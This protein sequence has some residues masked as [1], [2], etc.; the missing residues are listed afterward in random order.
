MVAAAPVLWN[1]LPYKPVRQAKDTDD[2]KRLV[3]NYLLYKA[4]C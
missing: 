3:K 4:F 1:S 2:F